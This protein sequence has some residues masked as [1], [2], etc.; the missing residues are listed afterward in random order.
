MKKLKNE[1][2]AITILVLVSILFMVSFLIS[3][4]AIVA[5]KVKTQKE[6]ISQTRDI[7]S[8]TK[9]MDEIY[10]SYFSNEHIIPIY[11]VEHFK[12]LTTLDENNILLNG[13]TENVVVNEENGKIYTYSLGKI[14]VLMNDIKLNEQYTLIEGVNLQSNGYEIIVPVSY[15]WIEDNLKQRGILSSEET[16]S[17]ET[18][19]R[20]DNAMNETGLSIECFTV[21]KESDSEYVMYLY[22]KIFAETFVVNDSDASYNSRLEKISILNNICDRNVIWRCK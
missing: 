12:K 9:N 5:N 10:N 14:Y 1:N 20:I 16:L 8:T 3:S 7:Y 11:T 13:G 22:G 4:Y 19:I 2:G 18:L 6:I 17:E 21:A 15:D